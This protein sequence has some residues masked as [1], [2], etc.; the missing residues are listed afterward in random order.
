MKNTPIFLDFFF[1][2]IYIA[3]H[4]AFYA[5]DCNDRE[6]GWER[7]G[8]KVQENRVNE[9]GTYNLFRFKYWIID[10]QIV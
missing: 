6:V 10:L 8:H 1:M 2:V 7:T 4:L 5:W 3:L 9:K